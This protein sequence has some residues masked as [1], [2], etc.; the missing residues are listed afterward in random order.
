ML[1]F[2]F[3]PDQAN[4]RIYTPACQ[5]NELLCSSDSSEHIIPARVYIVWHAWLHVNWLDHIR[6]A[7]GAGVQ[8]NLV[9]RVRVRVQTGD[10]RRSCGFTVEW[11]VLQGYKEV[12]TLYLFGC[13]KR[14]GTFNSANSG[15][16]AARD[17]ACPQCSCSSRILVF[18]LNASSS[19][20]CH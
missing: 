12:A 14:L 20:Q 18:N 4:E 7:V 15:N 5:E 1:W 19:Q 3:I 6:D 2:V 17:T 16:L 9:S 10:C 13:V 11:C 8:A